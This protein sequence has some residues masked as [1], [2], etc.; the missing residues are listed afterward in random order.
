MAQLVY[1]FVCN[2]GDGSGSIRYTRDVE[3]LAKLEEIDPEGYGGNEGVADVL[4]FPDDLDLEEVGFG[5][6]LGDEAVAEARE[7]QGLDEE[8]E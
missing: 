2:N 4:T 7:M 5:E 8:E 3:L 6:F 1:A